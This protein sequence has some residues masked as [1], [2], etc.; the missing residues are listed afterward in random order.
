MRERVTTEKVYTIL[1]AGGTGSRMGAAVNK[2]FLPV[3]GIPCI[4]RSA[5]ALLP[6]TDHMIAVY[7]PG[8]EAQLRSAL[9]E[10][11][12]GV[13]V[14][15][16]PGGRTRQESV[17]HG[18]QAI[19]DMETENVL[20]LIHDGARCLVDAPVIQ[21]V[22][23]SV[24]TRGSGFAAMPVTDTL[25]EA[26]ERLQAGKTVPREGLWAMQTPQ[27]ARL[28]PF[29][30]A[31]TKAERDGFSGTDDASVLAHAGYPVY[32]AE[33]SRS[34]LKLTNQEDLQMAEA[35]SR[36]PS[37]AAL[38]VGQ[39]FDVHQLT[40]GRKLILCG[41]EIPHRLGLLGHSDADVALHALMDALL[42]AAAMGDIGRHFPDSDARYKGIS[43]MK[44]LDAVME[45]ITA[46]G[47]R[48]INADV[49]ILAQKPKLAPYIP[50]MAE[51]LA[52]ALQLPL[53][54]V[55]VK[56]T[57]TEHLGFE[58]REEG[59]SAQAVCLLQFIGG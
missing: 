48:P 51:N 38:R 43:S 13:P 55:N 47:F 53:S 40:E 24:R 18:L 17:F 23:D 54:C 1:L 46:A 50:A 27:G 14:D 9:Q 32:L 56:A 45:K 21:R 30:E 29:L 7:H 5:Q 42:G 26:S 57:T 59:I 37:F 8:E 39:G 16:V 20:V 22:V 52:S 19:A 33:G 49:T 3:G 25:R 28:H 10:L 35:F 6:F 12:G 4:A 34:N 15:F 2:I 58:G 44:L 41:V 11:P 36:V 31:F